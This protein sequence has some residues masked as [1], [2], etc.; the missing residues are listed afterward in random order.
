M[1]SVIFAGLSLLNIKFEIHMLPPIYYYYYYY[2]SYYY[3]NS[4]FVAINLFYLSFH[5]YIIA[6]KGGIAGAVGTES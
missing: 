4:L 3:R 2:Y 5:I 6:H 1:R